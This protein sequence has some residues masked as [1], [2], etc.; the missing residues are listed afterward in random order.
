MYTRI[1]VAIDG[2]PHSERAL[3]HALGLAKDVSAALRIVHVV[4]AAWLGSGMGWGMDVAIDTV[5]LSQIHRDAGDKLLARALQ[6]AKSAGLEAD[7]RLVEMEMP[8]D[9]A[10]TLIA[11]EASN[12][13]AS[14]VVLGT[15]GRR[16]LERMLMGSVAE[17]VARMSTVPVLLIPS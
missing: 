17:G 13:P 5:Q 7:T 11:R 10:A 4:D 9:H 15:H 6:A 3:S 12:W 2:S 1:L 14:L 8:T 16:G